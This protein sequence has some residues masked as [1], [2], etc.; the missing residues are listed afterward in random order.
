MTYA[1]GI[2]ILILIGY[3]YLIDVCDLVRIKEQTPLSHKFK[4]EWTT[5][6]NLIDHSTLNTKHYWENL[7][8][9]LKKTMNMH[10]Q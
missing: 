3:L 8:V 5:F 1:C 4:R 7:C 9:H 10:F 6:S 2:Q